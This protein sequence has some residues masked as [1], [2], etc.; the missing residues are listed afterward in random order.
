[1]NDPRTP[2]EARDHIQQIRFRKGLGE[3]GEQ[4]S[5]AADLQAAL[6]V[7]VSPILPRRWLRTLL[8][9]HF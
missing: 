3:H 4:S 9:G 7:F 8:S 5:N 6:K 1:M 2:N